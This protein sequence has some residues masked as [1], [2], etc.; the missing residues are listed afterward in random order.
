M[1][2]PS[3]YLLQSQH[4]VGRQQ[5]WK[6]P[7]LQDKCWWSLMLLSFEVDLPTLATYLHIV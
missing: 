2:V 1:I 3:P 6:F 5:K 4:T 7:L